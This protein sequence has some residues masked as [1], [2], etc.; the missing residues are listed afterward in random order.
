[1]PEL[2]YIYT[3]IQLQMD[4]CGWYKDGKKVISKVEFISS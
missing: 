2:E 4:F 1:M 3:N